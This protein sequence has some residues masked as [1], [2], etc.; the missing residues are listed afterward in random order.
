MAAV[1][2]ALKFENDGIQRRTPRVNACKAPC[3][4]LP[5][6]T[7]QTLQGGCS[8]P[9]HGGLRRTKEKQE[10]ALALSVRQGEDFCPQCGQLQG[11]KLTLFWRSEK[12]V[13]ADISK[14]ISKSRR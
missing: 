8:A 5:P 14:S 3:A 11:Q 13:D 10:K 12:S 4:I 7:R 2:N 1:M 6:W 9:K